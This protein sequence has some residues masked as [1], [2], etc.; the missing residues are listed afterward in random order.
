MLEAVALLEL[1]ALWGLV[2]AAGR[3][4][5]TPVQLQRLRYLRKIRFP[6]LQWFLLFW[7][8]LVTVFLYFHGFG[9]LVVELRRWTEQVSWF[10]VELQVDLGEV[11]IL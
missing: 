1:L 9:R 3:L 11:L 4:L 5:T 2:Y 6:A 7:V 8:T 10:A